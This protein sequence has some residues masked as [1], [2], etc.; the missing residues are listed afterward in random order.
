M[1][2]TVAIF[3]KVNSQKIKKTGLETLLKELANTGSK[4]VDSILTYNRSTNEIAINISDCIEKQTEVC[5]LGAKCLE[6]NVSSG[7]VEENDE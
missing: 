7:K 4:M 1:L 5:Q 3:L 6:I 2:I